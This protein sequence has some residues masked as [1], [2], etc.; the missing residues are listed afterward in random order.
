MLEILEACY[1]A[2]G[3]GIEIVPVGKISEATKIMK[4]THNDF[5]VTGSTFPG[6]DPLIEDLIDIEAKIIFAHGIVS[7]KKDDK[8]VKMVDEIKS[9]GVIPGIA[10]HNPVSTLEYALE[11]LPDVRVFLIPFNKRGMLMGNKRNLEEIVNNTKN[12]SFVGMKTLAAGKLDPKKA[13]EY[14]SKH[15]ISAVTI[16]MVTT[17]EAEISTK[18]ALEALSK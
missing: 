7:D 13:Y 8:L 4:E 18:I 5:V 6:P 12:C 11:N 15:N 16:G 14:I 10:A 1:K 9:R 3:R 17:E 2:G